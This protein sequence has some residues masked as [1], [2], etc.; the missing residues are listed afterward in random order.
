MGDTR[1]IGCYAGEYGD[2][3]WF[4][5]DQ[6]AVELTHSHIGRTDA[7]DE[8]NS[9]WPPA[10]AAAA[11][12]AVIGDNT[13]R[14]DAAVEL[15][16][17]AYP[18]AGPF[19]ARLLRDPEWD[20]RAVVVRALAALRN[21]GFPDG[22]EAI[23]RA[24]VETLGD[25]NSLVSMHATNFVRAVNPSRELLTQA[26]Q[27]VYADDPDLVVTG[28]RVV[29]ALSRADDPYG[30]VAATFDGG[31]LLHLLQ[32][33]VADVRAEYLHALGAA[34]QNVAEAWEIGLRDE[35][36]D[37]RARA[38]SAMRLLDDPPPARI[39]E[40]LVTD[41]A[42]GV[43]IEALFT[44]GQLGDYDPAVIS[45]ALKDPSEQVRQYTAMLLQA[46]D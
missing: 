16:A 7:A 1:F 6:P 28:L 21:G 10:V 3:V 46:T 15:G 34:D 32:S 2:P 37:V 14:Y 45:V 19:L 11:W 36:P 25:E 8:V 40:P 38:L 30:A 29:V 42:E 13:E 23:V 12:Q 31:S 5:R 17:S 33:P 4:G 18:Q 39:V 43:R 24:V 26:I 27:L 20:V 41:P 44:L 9:Q 22:D 35:L